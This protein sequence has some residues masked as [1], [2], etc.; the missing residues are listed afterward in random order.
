VQR[1]T[2]TLLSELRKLPAH[3]VPKV[4]AAL[5]DGIA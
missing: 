5:D 3:G 4:Y 2:N 1:K